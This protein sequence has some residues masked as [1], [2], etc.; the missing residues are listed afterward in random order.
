MNAIRALPTYE[1]LR[2]TYFWE[3]RRLGVLGLEAH[4]TQK[5]QNRME[6]LWQGSV[7]RSHRN[8]KCFVYCEIE[9]SWW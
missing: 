9:W 3:S 1:D 2:T 6:R 8:H 4:T 5:R 7:A